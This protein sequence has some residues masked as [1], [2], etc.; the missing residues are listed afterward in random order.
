MRGLAAIRNFPKQR[1]DAEGAAVC[2][3]APISS[4]GVEVNKST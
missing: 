2:G 1:C 3:A 4:L